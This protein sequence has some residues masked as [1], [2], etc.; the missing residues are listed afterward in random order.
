MKITYITHSS[1]CVELDTHV[2]IFDYYLEEDLPAFDENKKILFFSS[3]KHADHFNINILNYAHKYKNVHFFLGAGVKLNEKYLLRN[4]IDID[5]DFYMTNMYKRQELFYEDIK[6]KTIRST[7]A[8]VAFI[9]ECENHRFYHAGDLNCWWWD[10]ESDE[11]NVR[12]KKEYI[13]ELS[14]IKGLHIDYAFVPLDPHLEKNYWMGLSIFMEMVGAN[15]VFPMHMWNDYSYIEKFLTEKGQ[16]YSDKIIR[17]TGK[18][19][20]YEF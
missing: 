18:N 5:R 1:F 7:D 8:G 12:M 9:V 6:I 20:L 15:I 14:V 4:N 10:G 2:L 13:E 17:I 11:F 19:Q 16:A 3:H